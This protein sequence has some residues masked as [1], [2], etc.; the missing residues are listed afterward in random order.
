VTVEPSERT[1]KPNGKNRMNVCASPH[2]RHVPRADRWPLG[3][4]PETPSPPAIER[5]K[6]SNL[7]RSDNWIKWIIL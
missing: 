4:A 6:D 7:W 1:V 5:S 3:K 2:P